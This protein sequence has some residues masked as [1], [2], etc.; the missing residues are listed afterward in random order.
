MKQ[1]IPLLSVI[2]LALIIVP[3][4]MYLATSIE[5]QLMQT[6]ML[7]GTVAWFVTAPLWIGRTSK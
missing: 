6:L 1:L 2:A 4:A 5:K 3:A 7:I